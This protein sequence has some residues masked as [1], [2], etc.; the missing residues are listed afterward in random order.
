MTAATRDNSPSI[1]TDHEQ[2]PDWSPDGH[3][4]AYEDGA[5]PNGRIWVMKA[6]GTDKRQ[7]TH[8]PGDGP[9]GHRTDARSRSCATSATATGRCT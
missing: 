9:R 7:L 6:D 3:E 8:G 4:I 5:S 1:I 2:L